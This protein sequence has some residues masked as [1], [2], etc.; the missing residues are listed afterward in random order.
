MN[1]P[2]HNPEIDILIVKDLEDNSKEGKIS[3]ANGHI[4][5]DFNNYWINY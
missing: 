4:T 2:F 1:V 3:R 5:R